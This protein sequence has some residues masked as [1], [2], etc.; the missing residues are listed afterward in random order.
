MISSLIGNRQSAI[1]NRKSEM[2]RALTL[3]LLLF[4]LL[5]GASSSPLHASDVIKAVV[6][7]F[8]DDVAAT[9]ALLNLPRGVFVDSVGNI[10]ISDTANHRIRK[11]DATTHNITTVAGNGTAGF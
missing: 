5:L 6:G 4:P 7:Y 8:G 9:S 2:K 11:V 1:G 10:F 3:F